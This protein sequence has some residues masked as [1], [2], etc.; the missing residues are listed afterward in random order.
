[1]E[2]QG[3]SLRP[4]EG[5]NQ[6]S[7]QPRSWGRRH[8]VGDLLAR[9]WRALGLCQPGRAKEPSRRK[10]QPLCHR[11]PERGPGSGRVQAVGWAAT[12]DRTGRLAGTPG[13]RL[14]EAPGGSGRPHRAVPRARPSVSHLISLNPHPPS[15]SPQSPGD[16]RG[17]WKTRGV[18]GVRGL[19]PPGVG[20]LLHGPPSFRESGGQEGSDRLAGKPH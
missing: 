1:M 15:P 8:G 14:R 9:A 17:F 16:R 3:K 10:E 18:S 13:E 5:R 11:C 2:T 6:P 20:P 4:R 7:C 19:A 12:E